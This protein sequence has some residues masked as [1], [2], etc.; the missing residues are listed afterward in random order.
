MKS[1]IYGIRVLWLVFS[2]EVIYALV[3]CLIFDSPL[4]PWKGIFGRREEPLLECLIV[5]ERKVSR[6]S[7][8][9]YFQTK[10]ENGKPGIEVRRYWLETLKRK[11]KNRRT[12]KKGKGNS[13]K[14]FRE[15]IVF[16]SPRNQKKL[17]FAPLKNKAVH[18]FFSFSFFLVFV[19]RKNLTFFHFFGLFVSP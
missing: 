13:I 9:K 10:S 1:L 8:F 3:L 16:S 6:E 7:G 18:T 5:C 2:S 15:E 19:E 4:K 14:L 17:F 12:R 11:E